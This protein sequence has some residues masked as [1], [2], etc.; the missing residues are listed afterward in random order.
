MIAIDYTFN[1][2]PIT[3][4]RACD[5]A[6]SLEEQMLSRSFNR[7]WF[8]VS[9]GRELHVLWL[10]HGLTYAEKLGDYPIISPE[11]A[12]ALLREGHFIT[13]VPQEEAPTGAWPVAH[14]DLVYRAGGYEEIYLPWYRFWVEFPRNEYDGMAEEL[15]C[16]GAY[17][18]PAVEGK[19]LT[20][21]PLWDGSF[22]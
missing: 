7:V 21:M 19:Y 9:E 5:G 2:V 20:N 6:G 13:T 22:N 17:Y 10:E 3:D 14:V 1:G 4:L 11:E 18:V 15:T 8:G 12:E 16:Y